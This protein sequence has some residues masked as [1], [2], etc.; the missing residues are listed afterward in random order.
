MNYER[1]AKFHKENYKKLLL[2]PLALFVLA[3]LIIVITYIK[4]GDFINR[5][6][7]LKGGITATVYTKEKINLEDL[8][9]YLDSQLKTKVST[10][11]LVLEEQN[12]VIIEAPISLERSEELKGLIKNKIDF[13]TYT[14]EEISPSLGKSFYKEL[15]YAII[16]AF[17]LMSITIFLVFRNIFISLVVILSV[18]FDIY[19]TLATVNLLGIQ[20]STAGIT[21]FLLLIGYSVDTDVLLAT[22]M[23]KRKEGELFY[24]IF[25]ASKTGWTMSA[26]T[27]AVSLT[28]FL[29][30]N[31]TIIKQIFLITSIGLIFDFISTWID[32]LGILRW[33]LEK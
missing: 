22:K 33:H 17:L 1:L 10:R 5:D 3:T 4:T 28:A 29:L 24:R 26:T 7:T 18:F 16:F 11:R 13:D 21:A 15:M 25:D 6:V 12:G 19:M 32:T 31:S 2:I 30:T 27:L 9:A 20:I 23:I 8:E 14:T